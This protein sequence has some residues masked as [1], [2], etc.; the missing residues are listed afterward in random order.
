ME[1]TLHRNIYLAYAS[2]NLAS[3]RLGHN[4]RPAVTEGWG[5]G[6]VKRETTNTVACR[7]AFIFCHLLLHRTARSPTTDLQD[8]IFCI[9]AVVG[10]IPDLIFHPEVLSKPQVVLGVF[11]AIGRSS[12][13]I[14]AR[15]NEKSGEFQTVKSTAQKSECTRFLYS[16]QDLQKNVRIRNCRHLEIRLRCRAI[17]KQFKGSQSSSIQ[18]LWRCPSKFICILVLA[19]LTARDFKHSPT[20]GGKFMTVSG[21]VIK[22]LLGERKSIG[23]ASTVNQDRSQGITLA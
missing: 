4:R 22:P 15:Y 7:T 12:V 6:E 17:S 20:S 2:A 18:D 14:K 3:D 23:V 8:D 10:P 16:S 13:I 21:F 1:D 5:K 11:W 19:W 9:D